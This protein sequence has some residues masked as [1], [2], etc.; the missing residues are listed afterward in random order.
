MRAAWGPVAMAGEEGI[1]FLPLHA[2]GSRLASC[3]L[4]ESF[5]MP[6]LVD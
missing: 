1:P 6:R 5:H 2:E 4:G 3:S